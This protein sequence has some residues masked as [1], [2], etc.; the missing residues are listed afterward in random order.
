MVEQDECDGYGF[1]VDIWAGGV[2]LYT[3]LAGFPPF[4]HRLKE[5][6]VY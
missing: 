5:T 2:V 1:E 6:Q 4:W 3:M